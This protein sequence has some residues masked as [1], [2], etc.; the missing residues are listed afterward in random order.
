[1]TLTAERRMNQ[2]DPAEEVIFNAARQL[3]DPEKQRQY[4]ELACSG[5]PEL[6]E[7]IARLLASSSA[8]DSF[9][10]RNAAFAA[11]V[12]APAVE[13]APAPAA[14]PILERVGAAI[15]RYKLLE[16]IGEGGF[17]VVFMA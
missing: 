11:D 2:S 15:G 13:L 3:T 9:F 1:M 10:G 5:Q 7:R 17:G 6:R 14:G 4:L 8:A 12:L 16:Q